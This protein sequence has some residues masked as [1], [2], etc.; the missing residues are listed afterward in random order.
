MLGL[1]SKKEKAPEV[2]LVTEPTIE[3]RLAAALAE[4]QAA[5]QKIKAHDDAHLTF[6]E[7]KQVISNGDSLDFNNPM[8]TPASMNENVSPAEVMAEFNSYRLQKNHLVYQFSQKLQAWADLKMR[9]NAQQ[10]GAQ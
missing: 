10:Q 6:I 9:V 8:Q 3:E 7:T 2:V 1:R 5:D 4:V